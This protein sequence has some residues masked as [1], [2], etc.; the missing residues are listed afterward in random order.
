MFTTVNK[1]TARWGIIIVL[2]VFTLMAFAYSVVNPLFEATDELRHY[3]FSRVI[4]TT[5]R[6]PVQGQEPCR[7]QSHHPPLFYTLGAL[8][9][10]WIDTGHD[11]CYTPPENPFWAY[12]YWEVGQDNKNQYLHGPDESFPW[13]GTALAVHLIRAVN[14]LIGAGVVLLTWATGRVIWPRRPAI[15]LGATA[16]VAFNPMFLYMAGA[17]NNDII[18]AFSGAAVIYGCIRL[19]DNPANINWRWGLLLGALYGLAL[20]SKFNLAAIIILIEAAVIWAVWKK[21]FT[22]AGRSESDRRNVWMARLKL[23]ITINLLIFITAGLIAGWWFMRNQRLFGEPTGFQ[24]LTNLWGVR[25]PFDSIGLALSEL[26]YAWT[27]LWGRFGFGQIPLPDVIYNGLKVIAT[28]G[29]IGT[30]LGFIRR[31]NTRERVMLLFLAADVLLFFSVL[32]NYML[33]S[34]AGPNGRFFFP[35]ISAFALLIFYGLY[36]MILSIGSWI[37][38]IRGATRMKASSE[39]QL[40]TGN[41]IAL[42]TVLVM[43]ALSVVVLFGYLV[44]AFAQPAKLSKQVE[45]PNPVGARFDNLA[46]FLGYE[47]STNSVRPGEPIDIDLF[48]EV[49]GQPPGNYL[50]FVHLQD[51]AMTM[52]AQ[53][54]THPGLGNYP[55][56]LWRPGDRF[57]ESIRLYVPETAYVPNPATISIGLYDPNAYRLAVSDKNGQLMGDSLPIATIQLLSKEGDYPNS[58]NQNFNNEIRLVGYEY[59]QREV[60]PGDS[61]EVALYWEAIEDVGNDY[62]VQVR[63]LDNGKVLAEADYQPNNGESPT[64]TWNSG[65]IT[66]D[67][68]LLN[69][70]PGTAAG[71]YPIVVSLI[72]AKSGRQ[73]SIVADDGHLINTHL[74]LAQLRVL[75]E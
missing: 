62:I 54:D 45:I 18:A 73:P 63:L 39:E 5:G 16:F 72:D 1:A 3:R 56:T 49:R 7:A 20:M 13:S 47:L 2:V 12:R 28:I 70:E 27:T 15:A 32:F 46:T 4:A 33:V 6:L 48:W 34:P 50:L 38:G 21:P 41:V 64:N 59:G 9:T 40:T 66:K 53:R 22:E 31:A 24:E 52:V 14:I 36:Q 69:I 23:W 42:A 57:R 29:L 37:L 11:T 10:V 58:Q 26:P 71:T 60:V 55:S 51:E 61:V 65:Q 68:H 17:I 67:V 74:T 44:V 25:D 19:L 30:L 35:A 43:L 8:A 75:A